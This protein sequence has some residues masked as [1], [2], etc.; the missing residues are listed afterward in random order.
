MN[1]K[2]LYFTAILLLFSTFAQAQSDETIH[3][4]MNGRGGKKYYSIEK[5]YWQNPWLYS[6]NASGMALCKRPF[7]QFKA[8]TDAQLFSNYQV[9]E[10]KNIYDPTTNWQSGLNVES[11]MKLGKIYLYGKFGYDYTTSKENRWRGMVDPY[12]SPFMMADSVAGDMSHEMYRMETKM[13]FPLGE[14]LSL[15]V[16]V[17][18]NVGVM[19]KHKDL[20]N[21]NTL[22]E[23]EFTPGIIYNG[24]NVKGGLNVGII[25]STEKIEY[26]QV[27]TGVNKDLFHMY[28]LWFNSSTP[29]GSGAVDASKRD[30]KDLT[31]KGA[32][33][34]ELKFGAFKFFNDFGMSYK[35]G[36]QGEVGFN[37]RQ[38]GD[39]EQI[40]YRY[41]GVM[42][43]GLK[44]RLSADLNFSNMNGFKIIQREELDSNSNIRRW[45][46]YGRANT[47]S[48]NSVEGDV[49][50]TFRAAKTP[51]I[52]SWEATVGARGYK[53]E[54]TFKEY[55]LNFNQ[56]WKYIEAYLTFAKHFN[57]KKSMFDIK[58][59]IAYGVGGGTPN[60]RI[61]LEDTSIEEPVKPWQLN[62]Q[63]LEEYSFMT[64]SKASAGLNVRYTQFLNPQAGFNI[65]VDID[66][67]YSQ[68]LDSAIKNLNRNYFKLSVGFT[69]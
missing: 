26:T 22:M 40:S 1:K 8:F 45:V 21:K 67:K 27:E 24:D 2:I 62:E 42:Q 25:T 39:I 48:R 53:V 51:W 33:Q 14:R 3:N 23:F 49:N 6:E 4:H 64:A 19:A 30:K 37:N 59:E 38:F 18:Y 58:P 41:R 5:L 7:Q 32:L 63:L 68:A 46:T 56:E 17:K 65:Y 36:S 31:Y 9:G 61:D 54:N 34:L 66:Y 50:Y 11:Y 12:S 57:W 35:T 55:P 10:M 28:G 29:F 52:I 60:E 69:F 20:R 47:F 44:H 43:Y 13:S 16:D 15:G